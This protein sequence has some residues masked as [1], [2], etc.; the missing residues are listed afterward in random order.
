MRPE[1]LVRLRHAHALEELLLARLR[2]VAVRDLNRRA[3][4]ACPVH[5]RLD[6]LTVC[7]FVRAEARE[8]AAAQE[9]TV[10]AEPV[11]HLVEQARFASRDMQSEDE[12][13]FGVLRPRVA[14][15][16]VGKDTS[17]VQ[18]A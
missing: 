9:P 6:E 10:Q 15:I 18:K 4:G 13:R 12:N 14:A 1:D 7:V 8:P 11:E 2:E 17:D 3:V 16:S 5:R